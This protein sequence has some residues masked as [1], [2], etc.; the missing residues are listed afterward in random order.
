MCIRDS[1]YK[2]GIKFLRDTEESKQ[3][4]KSKALW[5]SLHTN[6]CI[7][8]NSQSNWSET[9]KYADKVLHRYENNP[10]ARYLRGVAREGLGMYEEALGD[11]EV[12]LKENP[13][14]EKLKQEIERCRRKRKEM[15]AKEKKVYGNM[16]KASLYDEKKMPV[17]EVPK[18]DKENVRVFM[19]IKKGEEPAKKVIF[20]LFSKDVPKTAE[21]FKCFCTGEKVEKGY[22]GNKFHRI[23]SGF[24]MQ[25]GDVVNGDG[26]GSTS[27][28]GKQ[29]DD[30]NFVYK[31]FGAG[32][33]S[34]ANSGPNTN[35]SQFFITFGKTPHLD[36]KHVVFGRVVKGMST[37]R[38]IEKVKT[39]SNDLPSEDVVIENCGVYTD[40]VDHPEN[41][42]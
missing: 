22:K 4:D 11:F 10:K 37:I 9:I 36:G 28:Y 39:G 24:M 20:E 34:M 7:I 1:F 26:T 41:C 12:S 13:G 31:H 16:F 8:S 30:E 35:G 18:Y 15:V 33:L 29:F 5:I 17:S 40:D 19:D 32:L 42:S 14:D 6:L 21:N 2:E 27:I 25:G 38:E 3:T 23:I